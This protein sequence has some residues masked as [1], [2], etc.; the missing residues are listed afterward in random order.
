MSLMSKL[1]MSAVVATALVAAESNATTAVVKSSETATQ[2]SNFDVVGFV[3]KHLIRNPSIKVNS[4]EIVGTKKINNSKDWTAYMVLMDISYGKKQHMK[5]PEILFVNP[6]ENLVSMKLIDARTGQNLSRTIK[7]ELPSSYYDDAHLIAG[8][9]NAE[10]K[11]VVF[12]DPQCPFCKGFVPGMLKEVKAHPDKIAVYY[13]H[14][15][16]LRLHPVSDTLTRAME[17]LSRQGKKD[18]AMKMYSLKI[19]P[20]MKNEDKILAE[21][22]KQLNIDIKKE[23]IDKQEIKDAVKKDIDAGTRMMV[24]GTPTVYFD[25]KYDG[26]RSL[27]KQYLK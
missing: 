3:K 18:E 20:R 4:V 14:M 7:P 22:K 2:K 8:N 10:H 17:V 26:G 15:P 24:R 23:D 21:V 16:L 9:K 5:I 25:G 12:S 19:N 27:Y 6:K 13:Y 1:L 11:M